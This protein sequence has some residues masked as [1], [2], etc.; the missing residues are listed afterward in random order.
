MATNNPLPFAQARCSSHQEDEAIFCLQTLW[1]ADQQNMVV[2]AIKNL[3]ANAG[4]ARNTGLSP[5]LAR[6]SGG[7][8]NPPQYSC[9]ENFMNSAI[10]KAHGVAKSG[11]WMSTHAYG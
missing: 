4:D 6:S 8:D 7:Q 5:G 2:P 10:Y 9:L 1:F 11:I 3:P